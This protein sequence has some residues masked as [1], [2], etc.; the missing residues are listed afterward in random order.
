MLP[1]SCTASSRARARNPRAYWSR[2]HSRERINPHAVASRSFSSVSSH[3]SALG[4]LLVSPRCV[5]PSAF[6]ESCPYVTSQAAARYISTHLI[7]MKSQRRRGLESHIPGGGR[8]NLTSKA[9]PYPLAYRIA[10]ARVVS[11]TCSRTSKSHEQAPEIFQEFS[12]LQ[13][14]DVKARVRIGLQ[15]ESR[16]IAGYSIDHLRSRLQYSSDT[17]YFV[18]YCVM[19]RR[20]FFSSHR[21]FAV[22][23][24]H[25]RPS[26]TH[27]R[28][29]RSSA[30]S[31]RWTRPC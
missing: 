26:V 1:A 10:A 28:W 9:P 8:R 16:I 22:G 12:I 29:A 11:L 13:C 24:I 30:R 21:V 31:A 18:N 3:L 27:R 2:G 5:S 14:F 4:R 23:D 19:C 20:V 25:C 7:K 17:K 15:I 6:N